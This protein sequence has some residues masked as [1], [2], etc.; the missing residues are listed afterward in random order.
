M[1]ID[2]FGGIDPPSN[3]LIPPDPESQSR[4]CI[5]CGKIHDTILQNMI[6]GEAIERFE[7]CKDC[8][9]KP[10]FESGKYWERVRIDLNWTEEKIEE[11]ANERRNEWNG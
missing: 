3:S 10:M 7:K 1:T 6:T 9:M 4:P 8:I 2:P 5:Q 11:W